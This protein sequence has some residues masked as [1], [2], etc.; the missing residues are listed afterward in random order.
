MLALCVGPVPRVVNTA[1]SHAYTTRQFFTPRSADGTTRIVGY[2]TTCSNHTLRSTVQRV[3]A[4]R[5]R[6]EPAVAAPTA[7]V[8]TVGGAPS[9]S[10]AGGAQPSPMEAEGEESTQHGRGQSSSSAPA[11]ADQDASSRFELFEEPSQDDRKRFTKR[12]S[13]TSPEEVEREQIRHFVW[14]CDPKSGVPMA[15]T[16]HVEDVNASPGEIS[17]Q[18]VSSFQPS[19]DFSS[20]EGTRCR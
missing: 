14:S 13:E 6:S 19:R 2:A 5:V 15:E 4:M 3:V 10:S 18:A 17:R 9:S 7:A 16:L 11:A 1:T 20:L 8:R 12:A